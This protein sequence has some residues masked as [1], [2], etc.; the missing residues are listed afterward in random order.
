L[1]LQ[2]L[3]VISKEQMLGAA[4]FAKLVDEGNDVSQ[5][6]DALGHAGELLL[7]F[8]QMQATIIKSV[9]DQLPN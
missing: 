8:A 6:A 2:E 5:I 3:E 9:E 4:L 1:Q 7:S